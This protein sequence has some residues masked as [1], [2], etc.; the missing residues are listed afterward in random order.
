M[1]AYWRRFRAKPSTSFRTLTGDC[2]IFCISAWVLATVVGAVSGCGTSSTNGT[3]Y[4]GF[5]LERGG[6]GQ[7]SP[8]V[9]G[10]SG[11]ARQGRFTFGKAPSHAASKDKK[12]EK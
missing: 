9:G 11:M 12:L 8:G 4:G 10:H 3:K 2:P 5:T 7:G 1:T 6:D